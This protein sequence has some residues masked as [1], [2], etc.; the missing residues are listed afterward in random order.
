VRDKGCFDVAERVPVDAVE[1][2]REASSVE[3]M[4]VVGAKGMKL[5]RK[6]TNSVR[7]DLVDV[8]PLVGVAQEP[9]EGVKTPISS[10]PLRRGEER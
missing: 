9:A 8:Q 3:R 7:L 2:L 6:G 5:E 4:S 10:A 1:E